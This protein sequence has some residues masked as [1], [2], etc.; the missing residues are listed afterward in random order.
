[1]PR[2]K[3]LPKTGGRKRG[4]GNK[5]NQTFREILAGFEEGKGFEPVKELMTLYTLIYADNPLVAVKILISLMDRL[6]PALKA[7][8]H[9][10]EIN[11]PFMDK[12]LE[13]LETLV[14]EK[15]LHQ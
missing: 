13:E 14:K 3:G 4:S 12:T 8:E 1:M 9:S 6:Y 5:N 7:V 2:P 10:G 15:I 11:N